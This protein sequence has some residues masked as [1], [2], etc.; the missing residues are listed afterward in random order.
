MKHMIYVEIVDIL[1]ATGLKTPDIS[2]LSDEFLAE[3]KGMERKNLALEAL[4]KLLND[5]IRSRGKTNVVQSKAFS[6]ALFQWKRAHAQRLKQA[7][8][9]LLHPHLPHAAQGEDDLVMPEAVDF[10]NCTAWRQTV[11]TTIGFIAL[12]TRVQWA[13]RAPYLWPAQSQSH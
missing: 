8:Q 3:L 1:A 11:G 10:L 9:R 7:E 12:A 5:D 4:K 13:A 2:I 6:V